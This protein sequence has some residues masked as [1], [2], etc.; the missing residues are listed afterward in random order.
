MT[1]QAGFMLYADQYEPIAGMTLEQKGILL[2]AMFAYH[3]GQPYE[4]S[5]PVV[6][7]AFGHCCPA[8]AQ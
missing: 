1:S 5:D 6:K 2:E 4:I 3:S 8:N 7:M